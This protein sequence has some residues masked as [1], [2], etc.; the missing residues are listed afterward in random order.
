MTTYASVHQL[1]QS[2]Q[3]RPKKQ[4]FWDFFYGNA[5][6]SVWTETNTGGTGTFAMI[7]GLNEG[8]SITTGATS[9][10]DSEIDFNNTRQYSHVGSIVVA[11]VRMLSL[12]SGGTF[13]RVG[14]TGQIIANNTNMLNILQQSTD[15]GIALETGGASGGGRTQGTVTPHTNWQSVEVEITSAA[16]TMKL[17]GVLDVT[18]TTDLPTI[19]MQPYF[20]VST[21]SSGAKESRIRSIEA[22]NT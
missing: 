17:S 22:Y 7:N 6:K 12:V 11:T 15:G 2:S 13:Y 8:F 10:N 5:L 21:F 3:L 16:A 18:K 19:A 4:H 1:F 14:L 9:G 20:H